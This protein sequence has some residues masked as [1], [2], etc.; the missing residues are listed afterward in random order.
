MEAM[1]HV[2]PVNQ[3]HVEKP[4]PIRNFIHKMYSHP[5][6]KALIA[7]AAVLY[8]GA[9]AANK[10]RNSPKLFRD[11]S[12]GISKLSRKGWVPKRLGKWTARTLKDAARRAD[13]RA[14]NAFKGNKVVHTHYDPLT[15]KKTE[16]ISYMEQRTRWG[17]KGE[18]LKKDSLI[19]ENEPRTRHIKHGRL[20]K[21]RKIPARRAVWPDG[22]IEAKRKKKDFEGPGRPEV[23][24]ERTPDL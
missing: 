20:R 1:G 6:T 10:L 3:N 12:A 11:M 4:R 15:G 17:R 24:A 21:P 18:K 22:T 2:T 23:R 16:N 19:V 9:K 7:D 14:G 13:I 8:F 5:D